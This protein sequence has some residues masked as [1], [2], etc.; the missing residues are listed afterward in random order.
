MNLLERDYNWR[1]HQENKHIKRRIIKIESQRGWSWSG[2]SCDDIRTIAFPKWYKFIGTNTEY[3]HRSKNYGYRK[4]GKGNGRHGH[5][6]FNWYCSDKK[7]YRY[8]LRRDTNKIIE[9]DLYYE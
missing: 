4:R 3:F 7:Y 1:I 6:K 8:F 9:E 2:F 5:K